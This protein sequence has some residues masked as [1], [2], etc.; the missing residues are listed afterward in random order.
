MFPQW[1]SSRFF[2]TLD[3][4]SSNSPETECVSTEHKKQLLCQRI[5]KTENKQKIH[6]LFVFNGL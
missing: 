5:E 2:Y 1:Q 3:G 6:N 4:V